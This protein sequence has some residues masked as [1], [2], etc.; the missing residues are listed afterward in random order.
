MA[1][2]E[3]WRLRHPLPQLPDSLTQE[4]GFLTFPSLLLG[5]ETAEAQGH[6]SSPGVGW[7]AGRQE[8]ELGEQ[9][10]ETEGALTLPQPGQA[11]REGARGEGPRAPPPPRRDRFC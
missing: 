7:A 11:A 5:P 10:E 9:G 4:L 8:E 2:P 6:R 1:R 3:P